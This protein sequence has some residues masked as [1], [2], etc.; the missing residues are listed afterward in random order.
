M[1]FIYQIIIEQVRNVKSHYVPEVIVDLALNNIVV[2][3]ESDDFDIYKMNC[4]DYSTIEIQLSSS[5]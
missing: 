2:I 3:P 5:K 1:Q 4:N